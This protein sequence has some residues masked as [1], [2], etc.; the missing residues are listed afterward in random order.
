[1]KQRTNQFWK[2]SLATGLSL[3]MLVSLLPATLAADTNSDPNVKTYGNVTFRLVKNDKTVDAAEEPDGGDQGD[4][5]FPGGGFP[6]GDFPG[7]GDDWQDGAGLGNATVNKEAKN[8]ERKSIEGVTAIKDIKTEA[9]ANE[10]NYY[11]VGATVT[12][13]TGGQETLTGL[14]T[15]IGSDGKEIA[16]TISEDGGQVTVTYAG[17]SE[18]SPATVVV[19]DYIQDV[20][21]K[22]VDEEEGQYLAAMGTEGTSPDMAY[23]AALYVNNGEQDENSITEVIQDGTAEGT[24][25]TGGTISA[26]SSGFS[27][28]IVKNSGEDTA[29][30]VTI[31][32]STIDLS[33]QSDG[34]DVN[35]FAGYGAGVASFGD[36]TLTVIEDSEIS[37]DGVAKAAV[38]TDGGADLVVKSSTI[39]STGGTIY[40]DYELT[41]A[42]NKMVAPPWVLGVAGNARTSNLMG[43]GSTA[44]FVDSTITADGWGALSVDSGSDMAMY[45][46]NSNVDTTKVDGDAE[47]V[48][49]AYGAFGIGSAM[50]YMYGL[51]MDVDNYAWVMLGATVNLESSETDKA[52]TITDVSGD[53][54]AKLTSDEEGRN[55]T[56]DSDNFGFMM[57]AFGGATNT[58]NVGEGTEINTENAVFLYKAGDAVV[59]IDNAD[60][61]AANGVLFQAIDNEDSIVGDMTKGFSEPEGWS[62]TWYEGEDYQ[63]QFSSSGNTGTIIISNSEIQGDIYNGTG[64]FYTAGGMFA[65]EG[66]FGAHTLDVTLDGT[67]K[68]SGVIS[69]TEIQHGDSEDSLNKTITFR[70]NDG[71]PYDVER[72]TEGAMKLGHVIN[73]NYFNG[74]NMVNVTVADQ[75]VWNITGD[76]IV[77]NVTLA[78]ADSV[79]ADEAVAVTVY[80]TLTVGGESFTYT[81][82]TTQP[83]DDQQDGEI[84][85][86]GLLTLTVNGVEV[87][88]DTEIQEGDEAVLTITNYLQADGE[89]VGKLSGAANGTGRPYRTAVF[90]NGGEYDADRSV[91]A[92]VQ[93]NNGTAS[94]TGDAAQNISVS[95]SSTGF[96]GVILNGAGEYAISDSKVTL[97]TDSDGS[98][99]NDFSGYGSA[100]AIFGD[101]QAT[102]E[103]TEIETSGVAVSGV[104]TDGGSDVVVKDSTITANGGTIYEKYEQTSATDTMIAPPWDLGLTGTARAVNVMGTEGTFTIV[105]STV[106]AGSWAGISTDGADKLHV[107]SINSEINVEDSGYGILS[108]GGGTQFDLYGTDINT[109]TFIGVYMDTSTINIDGSKAKTYVVYSL[110]EGEAGEDH[111]A[112][113]LNEEDQVAEIVNDEAKDSTLTSELYGFMFNIMMGSGSKTNYLN[114]GKDVSI[115]TGKTTF[116]A[117]SDGAK[118]VV[119]G[120]EIQAD[121]GVLLQAMDNPGSAIGMDMSTN[122]FVKT[123]TEPE[124]WSSTWDEADEVTH[125]KRNPT[126]LTLTNT[127]IE[128]DVYNST[129][130]RTSGQGGGDVNVTIGEGASLT[131]VLAST[132]FMHVDDNGDQNTEITYWTNGYDYEQVKAAAHALNQV[133]NKNHFNG[134][135]DVNV[136]VTDDGEWIVAGDSMVTDVTLAGESS[137]SA[138]EDVTVTVY[139]TLTVDEE[140]FQYDSEE[141]ENNTKVI[142][143]VTFQLVENDKTV[144]TGEE[145]DGGDEGSGGFPGGFPGGE[146]GFPGGD[147]GYNPPETST[148]MEDPGYT[149]QVLEN[150]SAVEVTGYIDNVNG[151]TMEE[152]GVDNR[153][154]VAA[155]VTLFSAD[156]ED[157]GSGS[158]SGSGSGG[159]SSSGGGSTSTSYTVSTDSSS[160]GS[161]S[162][163]STSAAKGSTV[164]VTV[165][166]DSGYEVDALTVTDANG[167]TVAVTDLGNGKYSFVMPGDKVSVSATF[168]AQTQIDALPFTDV[169]G[170]A[171]YY[172]AVAYAYENGLMDGTSATTFAPAMNTT[173]AMLATLIYRMAGEPTVTGSASFTD[174]T[175]GQWYTDGITW[176]SQQGVVQGIGNGRFDPDGAITREQLAVMLYRYA[177]GETASAD[178]SRFQDSASISDW[179]LEAMNWAVAQG[180]L[181]GN[182]QGLLNPGSIASRAEVATMLMRFVENSAA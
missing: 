76:A 37:T 177:D 71:D 108:I 140:T 135:N 18:D 67:T 83:D 69:S 175:A 178:M 75:A 179:A 35:D 156:D 6:G 137:V 162:L 170:S 47:A 163:S 82:E 52:Y 126:D 12:T 125:G 93:D 134:Y 15:V 161:I 105:D 45:T 5:G 158:G 131:G 124:G 9:N 62:S 91:S 60:V 144:D 58:V 89:T 39:S 117:K 99:A 30:K 7:G 61:S 109:E 88:L 159:G 40:E 110:E 54:V 28:V 150:V 141:E 22:E 160:N 149:H 123:Y 136:T 85:V 95:G 128:G 112:S 38:F 181:S 157:D 115:Q 19:T 148:A 121:N 176:A 146:G 182:D 3:A 14:V 1:M 48:N 20:V 147:G 142:N 29:S 32:N 132:E 25:L 164:T 180:I 118:I 154:P 43:E 103:N 96:S 70:D 169:A 122:K 139:G 49:G 8:Y 145:P 151:L 55:T 59:T 114:L 174:V 78:G 81:E 84:Q 36:G 65:S 129:G 57:S 56:I 44:T 87:P 42:T 107:T 64:Y 51:D 10:L 155:T 166:P 102:I 94:V 120:T 143:N 27:G 79:S 133:A 104:V 100:V 72:A 165:T 119:D 106:N 101:T 171:W 11:I 74:Y 46:I 63:G 23:R 50:E 172:D 86:A 98:D 34:T 26:A 68:L 13:D 33:S 16:P 168:K 167:N 111:A 152:A 153:T 116:L 130:Y 24:N 53:E 17:V 66:I 77:N 138:D 31:S 2:K 173:R 90:V 92:A 41:S 4:S 21:T 127:D 97:D 80:G 113:Q 73:R